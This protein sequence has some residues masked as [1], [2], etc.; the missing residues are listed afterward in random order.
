MDS[1]L[2]AARLAYDFFVFAIDPWEC[3]SSGYLRACE[4]A[5]PIFDQAPEALERPRKGR[6]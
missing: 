6:K 4:A 5:C 3:L 1:T 2:Q